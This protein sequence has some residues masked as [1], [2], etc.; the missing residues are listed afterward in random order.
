[1]TADDYFEVSTKFA[2]STEFVTNAFAITE[3]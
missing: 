3:T 1:M 2:H